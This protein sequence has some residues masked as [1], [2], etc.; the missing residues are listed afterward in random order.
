MIGQ[1]LDRIQ[2]EQVDWVQKNFGG[3]SSHYPLLGI[4]EEMGEL[5]EAS[6]PEDFEDAI[7]DVLLYLSDYATA[8]GWSMSELWDHLMPL[9]HVGLESGPKFLI[10]LGR[11]AQAQIKSE[12]GIRGTEQEWRAKAYEAACALL[13]ELVELI[14][15]EC[16]FLRIVTETWDK[17]RR[18]DWIQY[19]TNGTDA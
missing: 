15:E 10:A 4:I 6:R 7:G 18:R 16:E 1:E 19:P 12:S 2:N 8:Q 13:F 9:N 14:G 3:R 5:A 11:L 17:V